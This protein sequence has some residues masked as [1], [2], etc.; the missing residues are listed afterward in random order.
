M[1]GITGRINLHTEQE[2]NPHEL[3]SMTD[4]IEHRGP[5][6]DG[7]YINQHVGLGFR[8]LSII[9]IH[10]GHQPLSNEDGSIWIV[11]NGEI[12]NYHELQENLEAQGHVFRTKSDTETI[13]HLYEQYGVEC[14]QYLRGMFAFSIWDNNKQQLFCARDRFGIKPFY[15]YEDGEKF[16]FG[17][18]IK[19]I[20]HA[21]N[22]NKKI[23]YDALNS[24]FAYGY[25]T[26]DLSIYENV[27]K[28]QPAHY[29]LLTPG[30]NPAI[31]IKKYWDIKFR[32]NFNKTE[33]QW[34]EE[35]QSCLSDVVKL[36][37]ISDVPLGAFLS[38]GIDSSSVVAMMA[39]NS[40]IPVE[41]FSIGF[42]GDINNELK[43]AREVAKKYGCKHRE[44]M[45]EPESI[46]L[47][48]KLVKAYDE[49][50]GD[51]SAI[52]TYYVSKF[53]REHVTVALSGDGGDELFAGYDIYGYLSKIHRVSTPF[54]VFNKLVWGS[55]NKA[56][57]DKSR[58][59]GL[60]YFLSQD[61][62]LLGAHL[63][64]WPRSVRKR[65]ILEDG[66]LAAVQTE[67][68]WFK[69]SILANG[70]GNDFITN[71]QHL[72]MRTYMVDSILTKV[73]R[74]SML[75]SLEVRVPLLD[76]KFAEL[77]FTIPS[78]LK[79]K[80]NQSK[81]I[82]KQAMKNVLPATV[83]S[84]PKIGFS[85]PI[86]D[87]FK[88]DLKGFVNDTLLS[89]NPKIGAYLDKEEIRRIISNNA[90]GSRDFSGRI[91]SLLFLEEWL[92]QNQ[93]I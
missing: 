89:A 28:L 34:M 87:W 90:T 67:P 45:V 84:G 36:H 27:R 23:S 65:M 76:H 47:L 59:K 85:A 58:G 72:D 6:D 16:V 38:G 60:T 92:N 80:G 32:P 13:V 56:F 1:C 91:W 49:P 66:P 62:K 73:D 10:S 29:L 75:N 18:E 74:A 31:E 50:F 30:K 39:R 42:K 5:D 25:I 21:D 12:Y 8:R 7:Y 64:T 26:S 69:E 55:V 19:S 33:S 17:S 53:A 68:E 37:M 86:S 88:D 93:I 78:T 51:S 43:N 35:I 83:L 9:D 52:P 57:P 24:Y 44:Q 61:K 70:N 79:R 48:P 71:L 4:C 82:L 3:K 41:T 81:Y 20:L 22:V 11:F 63:C 40:S 14:L 77:S 46:S 2:I 54:P 15:Y